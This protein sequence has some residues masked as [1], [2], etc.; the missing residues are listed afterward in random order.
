MMDIFT[1]LLTFLLK[2]FSAEGQIMQI[3]E[4]IHLP[5]STAQ[6]AVHPAVTVAF[7]GDALYLDGEL[8]IDNVRPYTDSDDLVIAPL[9]AALSEK[10]DELKAVAAEN[11]AVDFT[12]EI[13]LQGDRQVPF[14]LLKKVIY[15]AGQAEYVNQ[16]LAVMQVD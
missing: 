7:N 16:S 14:R 5:T 13:T 10:A 8:L 3:A 11:K 2:S 1:I 12:G 4:A 9:Y 15:T 6:E